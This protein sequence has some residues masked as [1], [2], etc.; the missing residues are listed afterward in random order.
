MGHLQ[1]VF[2][3]FLV[4]TPYLKDFI[5]GFFE[6]MDPTFRKV[7]L[8]SL[9]S[10]TCERPLYIKRLKIN[11][12]HLNGFHWGYNPYSMSGVNGPLLKTVVYGATFHRPKVFL[13]FQTQQDFHICF[14]VLKHDMDV[15]KNSGTQQPWVF[16]LKMIILGCFGGTLIFGN[17][18]I[19][20]WC[21]DSLAKP[22]DLSNMTWEN[23]TP[24]LVR[25]LPGHGQLTYQTLS[26]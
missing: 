25:R 15:S 26:Y 24:S 18:H 2:W 23:L 1:F 6:R 13:Q 3:L 22:F 20:L 11:G 12:F 21:F 7:G 17:T 19:A 16:L 10:W 14:E 9:F 8:R 5:R 4:E